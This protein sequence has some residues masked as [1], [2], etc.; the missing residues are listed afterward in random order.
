VQVCPTGALFSKGATVAEMKKQHNFLR[1]ILDGRER[2]VWSYNDESVTA[3][4]KSNG[5]AKP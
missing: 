1:W 2:N 3:K 5:K 4:G